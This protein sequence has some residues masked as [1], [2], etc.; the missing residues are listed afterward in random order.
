MS[1]DT[2]QNIIPETKSEYHN[3]LTLTLNELLEC[4]ALTCDGT[5]TLDL[6]LGWEHYNDTQGERL[7]TLICNEYGMREIGITPVRLWYQQ[8]CSKMQL[9]AQYANLLYPLLE[10][11]ID[12]SLIEHVKAR[13]RTVGSEFPQTMLNTTNGDYAS[14][15]NQYTDEKIRSG[16]PLDALTKMSDIIQG[17][18]AVDALFINAIDCLFTHTF[19]PIVNGY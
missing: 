11:D 18:G 19:A 17:V 16:N 8:Y 5:G 10:S 12:Y 14:N 3:V 2:L 9:T 1:D 13:G 7:V 15:G 6:S 4:Q